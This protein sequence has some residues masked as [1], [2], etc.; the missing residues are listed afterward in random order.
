VAAFFS[1]SDTRSHTVAFVNRPAHFLAFNLSLTNTRSHPEPL[2]VYRQSRCRRSLSYWGDH[3]HP[4]SS[5]IADRF[6][7]E[8]DYFVPDDAV[9]GL[10]SRSA[11]TERRKYPLPFEVGARIHSRISVLLPRVSPRFLGSHLPEQRIIFPR[12]YQ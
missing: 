4:A 12:V 2:T 5:A 9:G 11:P 10:N 3:W 1:A 8:A 7:R 6:E